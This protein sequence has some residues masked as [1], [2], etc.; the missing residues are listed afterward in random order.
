MLHFF[1][2]KCPLWLLSDTAL[3]QTYDKNQNKHKMILPSDL[4]RKIGSNSSSFICLK[5]FKF[6]SLKYSGV[7]HDI[8][9][10]YPWDKSWA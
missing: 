1:Q 2:K 10:H 3:L 6:S 9:S 5:V 7:P 8:E 4:S